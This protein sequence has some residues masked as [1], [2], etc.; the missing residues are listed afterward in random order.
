MGTDSDAT[1]A[2]VLPLNVTGLIE[3]E[4]SVN[5]LPSPECVIYVYF[6]NTKSYFS[7]HCTWTQQY[8]SMKLRFTLQRCFIEIILRR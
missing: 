2:F 7:A 3:A 8:I 6:L 1:F 5:R 4:T